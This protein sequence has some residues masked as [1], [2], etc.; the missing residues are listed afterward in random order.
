[1]QIAILGSNGIIGSGIQKLD[2]DQK[3][4]YFSR[5]SFD[6]NFN[7]EDSKLSSSMLNLK[8]G[9]VV[10]FLSAISKPSEVEF[11]K[12]FSIELNYYKTTRHIEELIKRGIF[13][14]FASTD[15]V[16][17]DSDIIKNESDDIRPFNFYS[18]T[19]VLVE[20]YF[21]KNDNFK[22]LR[23]SQCVNGSDSFSLYCNNCL[24]DSE[25][26]V[27][28]SNYFRNIF[29]TDLLYEFLIK[30][31]Q[32]DFHFYNIPKILNFGSSNS[33]NRSDF[34]K[35][36]DKVE[37]K[38]AKSS[39]LFLKSIKLNTSELEK[40]MGKKYLFDFEFWNSKILKNKNN[41]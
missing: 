36:F 14:L 27:L 15:Q 25:L 16:Y 12:N 5:N 18:Y 34:A 31:L 11:N 17:G 21:I 20:E 41:E 3:F 10:L 32:G 28:H 35:Y 8:K 29:S 13:I 19:K 22:S 4:L 39:N 1:M 26:V 7:L 40:L 37:L 30:L 24:R 2:S 9:D 6:Y 38:E 33:V 23:F